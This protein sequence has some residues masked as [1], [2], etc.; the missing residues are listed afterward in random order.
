MNFKTILVALFKT[1]KSVAFS[2]NWASFF[3]SLSLAGFIQAI[4]KYIFRDWTFLIF[5]AIPFMM[6]WFFG[7][8][9]SIKKGTFSFEVL[10]N[11]IAKIAVYFGILVLG[12]NVSYFE[13]DGKL[14]GYP[15]LKHTV[16]SLLILYESHSCLKNMGVV[17]PGLA[18]IQ[19]LEEKLYEFIKSKQT[20][21]LKVDGTES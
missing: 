12:H 7:T 20:L 21:N 2:I 14:V 18:L 9:A 11:V 17:Y 19:W 1:F 15:I 4:Q 8:W 5:L 10:Y 13:I 3:L 6:D 16:Y